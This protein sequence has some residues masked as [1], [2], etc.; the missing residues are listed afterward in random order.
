MFTITR[1]RGSKELL[2]G[3]RAAASFDW[4]QFSFCLLFFARC[5]KSVLFTLIGCCSLCRCWLCSSEIQMKWFKAIL[6]YSAQKWREQLFK[7]ARWF[8][9]IHQV[10]MFTVI[11]F[12]QQL[13]SVECIVFIGYCAHVAEQP[14]GIK[15]N[16]MSKTYHQEQKPCK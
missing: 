7:A 2:T 9:D 5:L 13:F 10:S 4:L 1:G 6:D 12:K 8:P 16:R 15:Q 11:L 3:E 14:N